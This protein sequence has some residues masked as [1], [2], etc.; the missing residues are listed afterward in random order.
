MAA[1]EANAA[2]TSRAIKLLRNV[3]FAFMSVNPSFGGWQVES[4]LQET[5]P[6]TAEGRI[7][8]SWPTVEDRPSALEISEPLEA[9]IRIVVRLAGTTQ[10]T[11]RPCIE[12]T[13]AMMVATASIQP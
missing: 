7:R 6:C 2:D 5:Y 1:P 12:L 3:V 8:A 9:S 10:R 13:V 4:L 11:A